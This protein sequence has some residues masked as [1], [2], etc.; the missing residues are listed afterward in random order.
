M[1]KIEARIQL[2]ARVISGFETLYRT[3]NFDRYNLFIWSDVAVD[4]HSTRLTLFTQSQKLLTW[5]RESHADLLILTDWEIHCKKF[6][7]QIKLEFAP[8]N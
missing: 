8:N 6:N 4:V 5:L 1:S 7:T 3:E 2:M